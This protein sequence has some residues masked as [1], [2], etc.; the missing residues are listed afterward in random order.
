MMQKEKV[1]SKKKA[2]PPPAAPPQKDEKKG[3][4]ATTAPVAVPAKG[5]GKSKAAPPAPPVK[6]TKKV[7]AGPKVAEPTLK[8]T[9]GDYKQGSKQ[10]AKDFP[11]LAAFFTKMAKAGYTNFQMNLGMAAAARP[12][13]RIVINYKYNAPSTWKD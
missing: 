7:A 3:K 8:V 5:N 9:P 6:E 1:P 10:F 2:T 4:K 13:K 12:S 11:E